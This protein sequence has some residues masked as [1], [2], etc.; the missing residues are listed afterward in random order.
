VYL[1]VIL[2]VTDKR[3]L[4]ELVY[5]IKLQSTTIFLFRY[6]CEGIKKNEN[7]LVPELQKYGV[8]N[9][10]MAAINLVAFHANSLIHN[11]NNNCVKGYNSIVA[12]YIGG[13]RVNFS[14]KGNLISYCFN[15]KL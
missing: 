9:D 7:N 8:W 2:D 12:K 1:D 15:I 11:V 3:Y 13:K 10:L 14:F 6:F 5:P 4:I